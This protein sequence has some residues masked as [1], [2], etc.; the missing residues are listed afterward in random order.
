MG[1]LHMGVLEYLNLKINCSDQGLRG[2]LLGLKEDPVR[3]EHVQN[4]NIE[5]IR[6]L[7]NGSATI[8]NRTS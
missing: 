6:D 5:K 1:I 7:I 4:K 2:K 3:Q 8:D